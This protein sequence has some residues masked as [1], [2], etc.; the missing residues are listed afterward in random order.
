MYLPHDLLIGHLSRAVG[1]TAVKMMVTMDGVSEA[2]DRQHRGRDLKPDCNV[3][4]MTETS[5]VYSGD[6]RV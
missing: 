3:P 4:D 1:P 2:E 6:T 5:S